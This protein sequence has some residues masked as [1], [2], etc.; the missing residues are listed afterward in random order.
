MIGSG[1]MGQRTICSQSSL[2]MTFFGRKREVAAGPRQDDLESSCAYKGGVFC[3]EG[4]V[5]GRF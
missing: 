1:G 2:V 4:L 3:V 5:G